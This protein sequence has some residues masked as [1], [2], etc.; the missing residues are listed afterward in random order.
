MS[1]YNKILFFG[2]EPVTIFHDVF[3]E[4]SF[5]FQNLE[6]LRIDSDALIESEG[7]EFMR[8]PDLLDGRPRK[9]ALKSGF[10]KLKSDNYF[11]KLKVSDV[12]RFLLCKE[13]CFYFDMDVFF[14][15]KID[16]DFFAYEP[17]E[18]KSLNNGVFRLSC[19]NN[20]FLVELRRYLRSIRSQ[21]D[22]AD[23]QAFNVMSRLWDEHYPDFGSATVLEIPII[24]L[25][26]PTARKFEIVKDMKFF[27]RYGHFW[28]TYD[29]RDYAIIWETHRRIFPHYYNDTMLEELA[30]FMRSRPLLRPWEPHTKR[31]AG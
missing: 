15:K 14:F 1:L 12:L 10:A 27:A 5:T 8:N 11:D 16:F 22:A 17:V 2:S 28:H 19:E 4:D 30:D 26:L 7:Y 9:G 23:P 13:N 31:T 18:K 20:H 6:F 24:H 29:K 21:E 25:R 3:T